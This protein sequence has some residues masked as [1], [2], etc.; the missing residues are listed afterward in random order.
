MLGLTKNVSWGFSNALVRFRVRKPCRRVAPGK[1]IGIMGRGVREAIQESWRPP[2]S[3]ATVCKTIPGGR[4]VEV[5][6]V[7][8]TLSDSDWTKLEDYLLAKHGL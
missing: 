3:K 1:R 7:R 5:I 8:G 4:H 6:A 2:S